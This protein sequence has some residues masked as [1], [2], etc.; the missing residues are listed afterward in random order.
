M[1]PDEVR[2]RLEAAYLPLRRFAAVVGPIEMDPDDLVHEAFV[3]ALRRGLDHV[4]D[5]DAYLRRAVI[6]LVLNERRSHV[7]RQA[8]FARAATDEPVAPTYFSDLA[9]LLRL[10]PDVRAVLWLAEV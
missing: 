4:D 1:T 6:N 5:V 10:S 7:R 2:A 9:D 3:R 8:A